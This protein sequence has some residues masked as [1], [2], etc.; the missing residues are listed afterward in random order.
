MNHPLKT[1][2]LL[3]LLL[4]LAAST[5]FAADKPNIVVFMIDDLGWNHISAPQGTMGTQRAD[6]PTPNIE[7]LADDGLSFTHAYAQPNC[8][9]SRAA[10]LT[11]QYPARIH[12][13][14][15]SVVSLQ[16]YRGLSDEERSFDAP[17]QSEDVAPKAITVAEA[18]KKNG[19][20]TAHIGKYHVGNHEG[21]EAT[22]PENAGFDINIG[23]CEQ[24][25]QKSNFGT[26]TDD[27][28][29]F[30]RV[31][32]GDF[33]RYA[34]PYTEAY[35]ARHGFPKE[36]A[37]TPKHITDA[38]CDALEDTVATL[39]AKEAPFYIQ[40][41]AYAVHTPLKARPDLKRAAEANGAPIPDYSGF[42]AGFDENMRRL[43]NRLEDPNGD[44]DSSDSI[45]AE[46]LILFTSDNGGWFGGNKPLRG[47]KGNFTE[48][49]IRIPLIACWPGVIEPGGVSDHLVHLIDFYPTYL[50]L[51]GED[52]APPAETHPLDGQS[53]ATTLR[54]PDAAEARDPIFYL[55]PG[56]LGKRAMP[57]A[58]V[59]ADVRDKRYKLTYHYE[60][61]AWELYCIT[62]DPGE[63]QNLME[64]H[65]RIANTLAAQLHQWL[66]KEEP[67]W[68][69]KYPLH[70]GTEKS[71]GPPPVFGDRR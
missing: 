62:D 27:G 53:F 66:S 12:N 68:N 7:K 42:I 40:Y 19:Y 28:W 70:Q 50:E 57:C 44:G 41:H 13:D 35:L 34:A 38:T 67:T 16:R 46:T 24:G 11:G 10:M 52:W 26:K 15:Y 63:S 59:I 71:A 54:N 43:R 17:E 69:P 25:H 49:G 61:D 32:R 2:F 6:T 33:D 5:L 8:A 39:A 65:P 4:V 23:G 64:S 30:A 47:Q 18:L 9:P 36:L 58:V 45:T 22:L 37:G 48:G 29:E 3:P 20:A 14:V 56:Y 1:L 21:G 60:S 31:G 51:A 55:F